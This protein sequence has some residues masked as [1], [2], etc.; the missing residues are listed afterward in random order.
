[1]VDVLYTSDSVTVMGGPASVNV[2][3][4]FGPQGPRGNQIYTAPSAPEDYFTAS[5]LENITLQE[6]DLF[7][8]LDNFGADY[9]VVYQYQRVDGNLEWV[10]LAQIFGPTGPTGP[11]G[12]RGLDS[13]VTGPTGAIGPT[14]PRGLQ[15]SIGPQGPTGPTGST[16]PQGPNIFYSDS[17]PSPVD[18][19]VVWVDTNESKIYHYYEDVDS[20]QWVEF[21]SAGR[22]G[23]Q[24]PTG[25]IGPQG[26]TGP[27]GPQGE[28]SIAINAIVSL[29][30]SNNTTVAYTFSSHYSGENPD[31][32]ALGGATIAFDLTNLEAGHPFQIQEDSGS[33]FSN[34]SS[35]LTH[36]ADDGTI[37]EGLDAQ[38]KDSGTVYWNVPITS[39][40]SW[41]Y[42][43]SSHT[44]MAGNLIIKSMSSI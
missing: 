32:Y 16:G 41:R 31:V 17:P 23:V 35:G 5:V 36:I 18:P 11:I 10:Q 25:P 4:D 1:M 15:G 30:V 44:A 8:N 13:N 40:S 21:A 6:F 34:I 3:L 7:F 37:S 14:G 24:G 26:A 27:T 39:T 19:G 29:D 20:T 9:G 42:Q 12:P 2:G 43:C 33:G 22:Q 28:T 38:E